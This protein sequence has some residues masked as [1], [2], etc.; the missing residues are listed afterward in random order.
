MATLIAEYITQKLLA[1]SVIEEGD[2]E[3]YTYGFF[4]LVSRTFYF[5]V[6][7]ITGILF[8]IPFESILFY[9]V[10]IFLRTYAGGIHAKTETA[11]TIL[12]ISVLVIFVVGIHLM[13]QMESKILPMLLHAGG[14]LCVL[15]FSPLDTKEKPLDKREKMQY[16]LICWAI[17]LLC[18]TIALASLLLSFNA[19]YYSIACGVC[20][21]GVLLIIGK[22]CYARNRTTNEVLL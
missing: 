14:S 21:E 1:L 13:G 11:C 5:L 20:L 22:I 10:F 6:T 19:I 2:K 12:T 18:N 16:R 8:G 17:I 7:A 4:L 15:M 3:I 9:V